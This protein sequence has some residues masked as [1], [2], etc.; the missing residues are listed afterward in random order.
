MEAILYI[1]LVLNDPNRPA[2][3]TAPRAEPARV[4]EI[5]VV[6]NTRTGDRAILDCLTFS[7]AQLLPTEKEIVEN[8]FKLLMKFYKR[9]DMDNGK[10]PRISER[11]GVPLFPMLGTGSLPFRGGVSPV[12]VDEALDEYAGIAH[13]RVHYVNQAWLE[14][15]LEGNVKPH[16]FAFGHEPAFRALHYDC[17]DMHPDRRDAFW[18][19]LKAA[20]SRAYFCG[21][22]HFYDHARVDDGDGNPNNAVHMPELELRQMRATYY[23]MCTQVDD[24]IGRNAKESIGQWPGRQ[25]LIGDKSHIRRSYSLVIVACVKAGF[26]PANTA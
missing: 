2:G 8:E 16:V 1:L 10:R 5:S 4:G 24:Q 20:G 7:S 25:L 17:L 6:G 9:F 19:S 12:T 21:H 22:D 14:S 3:Q 23:A 11:T 26:C 15:Q 18:N 13:Q